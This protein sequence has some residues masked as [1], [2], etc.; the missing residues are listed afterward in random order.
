M[1]WVSTYVVDQTGSR[2]RGSWVG[3]GGG[4]RRRLV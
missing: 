1:L 4:G 2:Y 3:G